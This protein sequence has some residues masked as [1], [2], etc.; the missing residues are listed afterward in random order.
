[1]EDA[2]RATVVSL[3]YKIVG[4]YVSN[5]SVSPD[6]VLEMLQR[7]IKAGDELRSGENAAS[8]RHQAAAPAVPIE[9]SIN[10]DYIVC[11][12]DGLRFKSLRRHLTQKYKMTPDEYRAR[13]GLPQNYPMVAPG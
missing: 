4:A 2:R 1:M 9:E 7:L 5:N 13:W 11:L 6:N 3:A 10:H 12:E 8:P